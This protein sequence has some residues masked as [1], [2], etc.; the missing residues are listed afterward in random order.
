MTIT[1][2]RYEQTPADQIYSDLIDAI[3]SLGPEAQKLANELDANVGQRLGEYRDSAIASMV[4]GMVV[5]GHIELPGAL[6]G[7]GVTVKIPPAPTAAPGPCTCWYDK[8]P[9]THDRLVGLESLPPVEAAGLVAELILDE[10]LG[11]FTDPS[12]WM[13]FIAQHNW[14]DPA[15][16]ADMAGYA[17][18]AANRAHHSHRES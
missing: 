5:D 10:T 12:D 17:E 1:Q 13:R 14:R 15:A 18:G 8:D 4:D 9:E 11:L 16:M 7:W 2:D 6:D 3:G